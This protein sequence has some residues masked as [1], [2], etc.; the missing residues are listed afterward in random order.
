MEK[1]T[2]RF[3]P[4]EPPTTAARCRALGGVLVLVSVV[5]A[6][7]TSPLVL[8]WLALKVF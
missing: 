2:P 3:A 8:L 5:T 4:L 6:V 7:L 1:W